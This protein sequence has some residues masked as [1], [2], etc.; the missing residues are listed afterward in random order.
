M[1]NSKH[2][3]TP[4]V[5]GRSTEARPSAVNDL[6]LQG[7]IL[8]AA[9]KC[10]RRFGVRRTRLED[11]AS[12]AGI[13]RPLLYKIYGNRQALMEL[14]I[15]R[16]VEEIINDQAVYLQDCQGFSEAIIEG[17]VK[18]I[19]RSREAKLLTDLMANNT[20]L[21]MP[22]LV[23]DKTKPF[24]AIA[25]RIWGPVFE[26]GRSTGE[27]SKDLS[28]DDLFEWLM[29]VHYMFLLRNEL[30]TDRIRRLMGLFLS[31]RAS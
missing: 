18:G 15:A 7:R 25:M 5:V 30:D 23:L 27:L 29:S 26:L 1:P 17:S 13:S 16:E 14:L 20:V 11:I 22:D 10:F 2:S 21:Q 12:A 3:A 31:L 8:D 28:D 6:E 4:S 24:N 9:A 19:V